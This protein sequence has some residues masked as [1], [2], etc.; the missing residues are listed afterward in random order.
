MSHSAREL[1]K[2]NYKSN[3]YKENP[4]FPLCLTV[5]K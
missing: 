2:N 1:S 3:S 5:R 4:L